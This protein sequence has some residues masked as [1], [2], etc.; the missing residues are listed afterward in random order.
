LKKCD[1]Y[2]YAVKV[3]Y[4][5]YFSGFLFCPSIFFIFTYSFS[6][7][8]QCF[9]WLAESFEQIRTRDY[10]SAWVAAFLLANSGYPSGSSTLATQNTVTPRKPKETTTS[11]FCRRR[12]K[13][14]H[15]CKI[16]FSYLRRW[17]WGRHSPLSEVRHVLS[18]LRR[19]KSNPAARQPLEPPWK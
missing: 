12:S 17:R 11:W 10:R 14:Y 1:W 15:R 2:I 19:W 8:S 5:D 16:N 7:S 9:N 4:R 18:C 3:T 6:Y 13:N